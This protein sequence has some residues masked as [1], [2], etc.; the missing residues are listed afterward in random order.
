[1][2]YRLPEQALLSLVCVGRSVI[3]TQF[4]ARWVNLVQVKNDHFQNLATRAFLW[5]K[6]AWFLTNIY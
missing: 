3:K 5:K 4:S 1:M 2:L 6:M